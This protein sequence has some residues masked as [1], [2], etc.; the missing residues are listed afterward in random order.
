MKP[1]RGVLPSPTDPPLEERSWHDNS[2][3]ALHLTDVNPEEGTATLT[4]DI[5]HILEWIEKPR[6]YEFWIAPA[7][8][9]FYGVFGLKV[10]IDYSVGP[11]AVVPF[12]IDGI[13]R[14]PARDPGGKL[15]R[16]KLRVN[17][18]TGE[19]TFEALGWSLSFTGTPVLSESQTLTRPTAHVDV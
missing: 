15:L 5:D 1:Q 8:L 2:V 6:G 17:C 16:W 10:A 18:P 12:T 11:M 7:L 13:E 19:I 14:T 9:K 4:L 3:H